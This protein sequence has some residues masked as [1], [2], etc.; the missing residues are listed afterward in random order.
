[1]LKLFNF[2]SAVCAQKVR[3]VLSEKNLPWENHYVNISN[4]EQNDPEY[5]A[6]NPNAVVPTLVHDDKVIIES[7]VINE[8]LDEVFPEIPLRPDDAYGKALMR[9][10]TKQ[11]DERIHP[12]IT[13]VSFC[14]ALRVRYLTMSPEQIAERLRKIPDAGRLKRIK[15]GI[16]LGTGAPA[17][18]DAVLCMEKLIRSIDKALTD[19]R[20]WLLGEYLTLA[21]TNFVP[22]CHRLEQMDLDWMFEP[23]P[24]FQDW[25]QR[26]KLRRSFDESFL[27]PDE[28]P[29]TPRFS[30]NG[31][32]QWPKIQRILEAS[33]SSS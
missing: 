20:T 32:K 24:H 33:G 31:R 14:I 21:D 5:L 2:N 7:T 10:W 17:F 18:E 4:D 11:V 28:D 16:E 25:Y 9:I 13:V 23:Y 30:D 8:Y 27:K 22:Y 19:G 26:L 29:D 1:M 3:L 15:E 12:A 6:L